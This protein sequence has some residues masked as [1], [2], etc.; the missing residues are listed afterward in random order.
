MGGTDRWIEVS[1]S[2]FP[3]EAE[4][5]ARIRD[6]LPDEAPFRAWSNFEFRDGHGRWHEVDL[7]LLGRGQLHLIELKYYSGTLRGDDQRWLRDGRRPED[8]PLKLARRKAQYL[9]SK[10]QDELRIWAREQR[11][12][13]PDPRDVVPYVQ[14]SVFLHH[15][16][17]R[18]LLRE[19]ST[20]D[21][22]GI[23]GQETRS[24]LPGVSQRILE[25]A[26]RRPVTSNREQTLITLLARIGLIQRR[27]REAGSWVI[28]NEAIDS[29]E[30]WQD[31]R[32]S[33][34]V[35]QT[36]RARIR[37]RVLPPTASQAEKTAARQIAEHEFRLMSRLQHDGLLR[38]R[39]LVVISVETSGVRRP[40][41]RGRRAVRAV[42]PGT[43][44]R[45][46][47]RTV[48]R[49]RCSGPGRSG[50]ARRGRRGRRSHRA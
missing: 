22:F 27:D 39:D 14:E 15:P 6:L 16:D 47:S 43:C 35:A 50:A 21:L 33:H 17:F 7:L 18:C 42:G 30:G 32:A 26:G 3:H 23:D 1:P 24:N 10:L 38:P 36:D 20:I 13:I 46:A 2:Q 44:V 40:S 28:E 49:W 25:P 45:S 48:L 29:G 11:V 37:F 31:W 34:R 4:G 19:S 9:A 41:V 5:L 12:Q 8:S